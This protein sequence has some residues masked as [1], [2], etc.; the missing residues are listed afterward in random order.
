[1]TKLRIKASSKIMGKALLI[2]E[3][4]K[5]MLCIREKEKEQGAENFFAMC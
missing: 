5:N 2:L 4:T 3:L 1:M